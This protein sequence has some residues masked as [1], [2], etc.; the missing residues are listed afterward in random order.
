MTEK[1]RRVPCRYRLYFRTPQRLTLTALQVSDVSQGSR[2]LNPWLRV[3]TITC[4]YSI[5]FFLLTNATLKISF[6][7]C[8]FHSWTLSLLKAGMTVSTDSSPGIEESITLLLRKVSTGMEYQSGH[9]SERNLPELARRT[10]KNMPP[11][12]SNSLSD[13]LDYSAEP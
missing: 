4:H 13:S 1:N 5:F 9:Q 2:P 7:T 12:E 3:P 8:S 11:K 6:P 10:D